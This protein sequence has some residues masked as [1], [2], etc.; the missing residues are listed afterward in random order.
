TGDGGEYVLVQIP[1]GNYRL[2]VQAPGFKKYNRE[3]LV[4]QV[5]QT[6]ALDVS[7]E[8]GAVTEAVQVTAEAPLLE[9]AN[10]FLGEVVNKRSAE[11]LPLNTRN[12]TQLVALTPGI[13]SSPGFRAGAFS[14]GNGSRVA[15]SANGGRGQTNEVILDGSP[16]IVMGANQPAYIPMPESVQEFN[17]QTNSLPAE[18][19]RTGG[20]VVNIVHRSGT[21][22]F[23][24][25]L[26]EFLRNDKLNANP[27]FDNRNG[28]SKAPMRGHEVGFALG[29]PMSKSRKSTFFFLNF[30]RILVAAPAANTFTVPTP[31]MKNGDLGEA[32]TAVYDPETIDASGAR[33]PFP[34]N[35]IPPSR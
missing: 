19:G 10:S 25:V 32:P 6:I 21:K 23:H 8:L 24:G 18:Y 16:Q 15:F 28:K 2:T 30:Q 20:A 12:L 14:S 17:V 27:F 34:N 29:G 3:G 1:P 9:S 4:L 26:Y 11:A 35:Q 31:R 7:L 33:R 22:D 13:N 5:A